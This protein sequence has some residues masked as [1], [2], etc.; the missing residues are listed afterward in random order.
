MNWLSKHLRL[1]RE[2][3]NRAFEYNQLEFQI[4]VALIIYFLK[5]K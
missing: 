5:K 1:Y 2:K 3:E 4:E